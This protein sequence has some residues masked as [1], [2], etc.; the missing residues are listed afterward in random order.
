M[1]IVLNC[2]VGS[3][4]NKPDFDEALFQR[5]D[6]NITFDEANAD[7]S[8]RFYFSSESVWNHIIST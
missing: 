4:F 3:L 8:F 1:A 5:N 7:C 2:C 6:F